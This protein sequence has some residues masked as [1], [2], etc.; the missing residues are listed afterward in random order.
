MDSSNLE[1][2]R[3]P[4]TVVKRLIKDAIPNNISVS[5]EATLAIARSAAIFVVHA[6]SFA[7]EYALAHNRKNITAAD[8][9]HAIKI[10]ECDELEKPV[11]F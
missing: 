1:D 10:L 8:V 4:L 3:L 9:F 6:T 5:K 11:N 7:N 2:L